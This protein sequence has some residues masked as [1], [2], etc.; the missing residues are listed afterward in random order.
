MDSDAFTVEEG[1]QIDL[2]TPMVCGRLSHSSG[3]IPR[4]NVCHAH[5]GAKDS[6]RVASQA[7]PSSTAQ[8]RDGVARKRLRLCQTTTVQAIHSSVLGA[9]EEDLCGHGAS[10]S[11]IP[12]EATQS[13]VFVEGSQDDHNV[14]RHA[15]LAANVEDDLPVTLPATSGQVRA[16]YGEEGPH[17]GGNLPKKNLEERFRMFAEGRW[18]QLLI[19]SEAR[20]AASPL[21]KRRRSMNFS[22]T[23]DRRA[24]RAQHL[25]LMGEVSSARHALD[26]EPVAPGT[27]RTFD[28]LSDPERRPTKPYNPMPEFLQN[29][30]AETPFMLDNAKLLK[31]LKCA[32]RGAAAGPFTGIPICSTTSVSCW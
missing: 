21:A 3:A 17:R 20:E 22:D 18:V 8:G 11:V 13:R 16:S 14:G 12:R 24:E 32:R 9:L 26:G 25:V 30:Q 10:S 19:D 1:T 5:T 7:V 2:D 15:I 28:L 27:Q 31:N 23:I 4:V 6:L 29:Y